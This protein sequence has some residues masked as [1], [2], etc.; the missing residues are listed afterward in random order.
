MDTLLQDLRYALR[1]LVRTRS[2]TLVSV[3]TVA[4]GIGA[5]TVVFSLINALLLR[6]LPVAEPDG[7]VVVNETRRGATMVVSGESA[8]TYEHYLRYRDASCRIF[9]GLAAHRYSEAALRTDGPAQVVNAVVTS[10]NYFEVLGVQPLLGSFYSA[11]QDRGAGAEPVVVLGSRLWRKQFAGDRSVIGQTVYLNSRPFTVAG[12]APPQ[13]GGTMVGVVA[14]VWVPAAA[15]ASTGVA[16]EGAESGGIALSLFGR[17]NPGITPQM[18]GAALTVVGQQVLP[19]Q[20]GIEVTG[21]SVR[22]LTPVPAFMRGAVIGFMALLLAT[23]G[24]VLLIAATNVAGILLAR[25]AARRREVA[26]RLAIG[27]SRTRIVRQLLTESVLLFMAGGAA[28][29]L[30]A[31]WLADL[32]VAFLPSTPVPTV[33]DI[34]VDVRVLGFA[35]ALALATGVLFGLAPALQAT[36]PDMV[37]ALKESDAGTGARRTRLR[38]T[39]VVAQLAMSLLLLITA[40]LFVRTLQKA[41]TADIGLDP[42]GVVIAGITLSPHG[43]NEERARIFYRLLLERLEAVPA[44]HSASLSMFAPL[45]GNVITH[46]VQ[47]PDQ[48]VDAQSSSRM[49]NVGVVAPGYFETM[50]I[51]LLAGRPFTSADDAGAPPVVIVNQTMAE[52]FWPGENPIGQHIRS[53]GRELQVVGVARDGKYESYRDQPLSF[54]Y[55]PLEQN[56]EADMTV[57]VRSGA[58]PAEALVTLQREVAALDPDIALKE[59]MPL[60]SRI[61]FSLF[62]QRLAAVMVGIFGL[63]GLLLAAIGIYGILAYQVAQRTREI[64]IRMA[65]G[66]RTT[67]IR[68]MF[69]RQGFTLTVV[70][71][72]IGMAAAFALTRLLSSLLF[73]VGATDPVTFAAVAVVLTAVAV[74]ASYLPARAA[75]RVDPNVALRA[76]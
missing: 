19:K 64:G 24:L 53:A 29:V 60:P 55:L 39:F 47:L 48:P 70:G 8:F 58:D 33:L 40:G 54:L 32:L 68:R 26:I 63:V 25:A 76:E 12:I 1:T 42:D 6:P 65:L 36:R 62:P 74:L 7:L 67:D 35:L 38:S 21:A 69:V 51:P 72:G 23:A 2:A 75:T 3:S 14:D 56:F 15:Y 4:L 16:G 43:Y 50:R 73:E 13:F 27:A 59:A 52:R 30:L 28:G 20:A 46:A 49:A 31:V 22:P 44:I 11:D 34:S 9:S 18:A 10:G 5:T 61:G 66:A 71:L 45:S 17:L 57:L 37:P 41:L